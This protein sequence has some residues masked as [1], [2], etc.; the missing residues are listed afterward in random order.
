MFSR[1]DHEHSAL[2]K[3][4]GSLG[5]Q[6]DQNGAKGDSARLPDSQKKNTVDRSLF[7][8]SKQFQVLSVNNI[9]ISEH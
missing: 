1:H 2:V 8:T 6:L 7:K 3:P 5:L 9:S 4:Y